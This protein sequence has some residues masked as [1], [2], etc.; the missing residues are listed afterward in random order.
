MMTAIY[1]VLHLALR[2]VF[3]HS[4]DCRSN[5]PRSLGFATLYTFLYTG[6]LFGLLFVAGSLGSA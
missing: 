3:A 6:W 5:L 1:W 4:D 2:Q